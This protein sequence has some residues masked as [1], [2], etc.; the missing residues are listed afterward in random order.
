MKFSVAA[1]AVLATAV[2][3][4]YDQPP[5]QYGQQSP[6]QYGQQQY[7]QPQQYQYGP[8]PVQNKY[9]PAEAQAWH[10]C[11]NGLLDQF[12]L[13]HDKS[14]AGCSFWTCLETTAGQYNRGGALATIG[15]GVSLACKGVGFLPGNWI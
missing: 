8:P 9:S 14:Q 15:Q 4:Q 12:N 2:S 6:Q 3:A 7:Q 11:V 13:G 10:N 1:L 5:Q